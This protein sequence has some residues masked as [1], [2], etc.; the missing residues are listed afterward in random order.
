M[1]FA[2]WPK[3]NKRTLTCLSTYPIYIE[4][5]Y[6][7]KGIKLRFSKKNLEKAGY[8]L[9]TYKLFSVVVVT[10]GPTEVLIVL[11]HLQAQWSLSV[12]TFCTQ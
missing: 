2:S 7:H 12:G 4:L 8:S 1:D 3:F 5:I 10:I 9:S 6:F 11:G